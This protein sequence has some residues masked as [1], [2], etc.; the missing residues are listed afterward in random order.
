MLQQLRVDRTLYSLVFGE[1]VLNDAVAIVMYH[2]VLQFEATPV[3]FLSVIRGVFFFLETF[4]GSLS[5]GVAIGLCS[6]LLF[7]FVRFEVRCSCGSR[8]HVL[9]GVVQRVASGPCA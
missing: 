1:S 2:T 8:S 6:A 7:K 4:V 9:F 5:I 3:T